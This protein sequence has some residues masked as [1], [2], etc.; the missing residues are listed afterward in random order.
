MISSNFFSIFAT[1]NCNLMKKFLFFLTALLCVSLAEA[2]V[3]LPQLFQSGMV[4]QRGK[5]IPIWGKAD[6]GE[7]VTVTFNKKQYTTVADEQGRWRV[8]LPKMKAGG[9]YELTVNSL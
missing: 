1:S 4:L 7:T 3:S 9:P 8:D 6:V 2:K 5:T